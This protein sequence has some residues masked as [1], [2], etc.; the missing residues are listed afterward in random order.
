M[1]ERKL[2]L[3]ERQFNL[4]RD[5]IIE[6]ARDLFFLKGYEQTSIDEIASK[7]EMSKSTLYNYVKSKEELFMHIH[8][9]GMRE[10]LVSL[11]EKM[12]HANNGFEKIQAFGI[13]YYRFYK[14]NPGYFKLHAYEDYNS[15]DKEKAGEDLCNEFEILLEQIITLVRS[16][17]EDGM[18][19][20]SIKTQLDPGYLDKYYAYTLRAILNITFN[21]EKRK[22]IE[23]TFDDQKFYMQYL[24]LFL[25]AI[26]SNKV[27]GGGGVEC[28]LI[29]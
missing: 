24:E 11:T 15:I 2:S 22:E 10:R 5:Y 29:L 19:D 16:A 6:I 18:L 25:C 27:M 21:P 1:N 13:E 8:L 26:K 3:K 17:F 20:R 23:K 28:K 12:N 9:E 4:K 14:K 7:A